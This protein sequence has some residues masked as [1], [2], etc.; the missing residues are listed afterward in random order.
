MQNIKDLLRL[1]PLAKEV[2]GSVDSSIRY[3]RPIHRRGA[4][5]TL[6]TAIR[7]YIR[8]MRTMDTETICQASAAT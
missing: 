2:L 4:H 5:R 1:G 8:T 7:K 3:H 6:I